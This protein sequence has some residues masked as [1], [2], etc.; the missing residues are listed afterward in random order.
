MT[1]Y[2]LSGLSPR[3]FEQLIQAIAVK[4]FG[5]KVVVFGDGPD[6]GREATF[7]G[8]VPYPSKEQG[9]NGYGIVQ[10]K[11][12]QRPLGAP[13]D[14]EWA[15]QQLRDEVTAFGAQIKLPRRKKAGPA[16]KLNDLKKPR[17][18]PEYYIFVSNAVLTPAAQ[19][20]TKDKAYAVL[21]EFKKQVGLKDFDIWDYDKICSYLDGYEDV[22]HEYGGFISTG[23]V[24]AQV[25]QWLKPQRADFKQVIYK[26]LQEELLADQYANLEQAGRATEDKIPIARVFVDLPVFA[27]QLVDPPDEQVSATSSLPTG[28]IA[29]ILEAAKERLDPI[30]VK[31]DRPSREDIVIWSIS[32]PGRYVLIG[33]PGQGKTTVGQFVCQLFRTAILKDRTARI[34]VREVQDILGLVNAQCLS[35]KIELPQARRFPIRIVLSDFAKS[36][37]A[38]DANG[39]TSLLS[40]IAAR[41]KKRTDEE[42]TPPDLRLWLCSYPWLIV[43]DGLDEVPASSNRDEVLTAIRK[44][45]IEINECNADVLIIATTRP[46]GYNQ[47]FAP[48]VYQH[49]WLAPL[50][51]VRALHYARRLI[52]VRYAADKD[53]KERVVAR[54]ERAA[55]T[56]T[57]AR[58]MRSPL[59]VTIMT[60]L[61]GTRG[62]PPQERWS[63]FNEYYKVIYQ[64]EMERE[65][66][67]SDILRTYKSDIDRIHHRVGLILQAKS[68]HSGETDARLSRDEFALVVSDR[69]TQEE[70]EGTER[71]ALQR[72]IT[73]AATDRLVFLVGLQDDQIGFEIRSLQEFMAAEALMDEGGGIIHERLREIAPIANWRNVFL[74]AAGKCFAERQELRDTIHTVCAELNDTDTD[75]VSCTTL[76]GSELAMDLLEDGVARTQPKYARLFTRLALRILRLPPLESHVRLAKLYESGLAGVYREEIGQRL[77]MADFYLQ[78]GAWA[79]LIRLIAVGVEW[80]RE[81][82][83]QH[84]VDVADDRKL[85]LLRISADVNDEDWRLSKMV[86]VLPRLAPNQ[87]TARLGTRAEQFIFKNIKGESSPK[88]FRAAQKAANNRMALSQSLSVPVKLVTS[89]NSDLLG[90]TIYKT[91]EA[92][93]QW[94]A[95]LLHMPSN[96]QEGWKPILAGVR[97][98]SDPSEVSLGR[99]L[100]TLATLNLETLKQNSHYLPWTIAACVQAASNQ[101]DL[102]SLA[103]KAERGELGDKEHWKAAEERWEERGITHED[104]KYA[105]SESALFDEYI[106]VKGFPFMAVGTWS[107]AGWEQPEDLMSLV[108]LHQD[109]K[110]SPIRE[111]LCG[112]ALFVIAA[113]F[114]RLKPKNAQRTLGI[115]HEQI[116]SI[117]RGVGELGGIIDI[118]ALNAVEWSNVLNEEWIEFLDDLGQH[119]RLRSNLSRN[120]EITKLISDAFSAHPHRIGLLRVLSYFAMAGNQS[121][122]ASTLLVPEHYNEPKF[123]GAAVIT[124]LA[125][126]KME[127]EDAEHLAQHA[128]K[129]AGDEYQVAETA[130]YMIKENRVLQEPAVDDFLVTLY[131]QLPASFW[132]VASEANQLLKVSL[133]R[134]TSRLEDINLW[135]HLGLRPALHNL[136]KESSQAMR[137]GTLRTD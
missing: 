81:Y 12:L 20:G 31:T 133:K 88:W 104:I 86:D 137:P 131:K 125:Q 112:W 39:T 29:E 134:R 68:E 33:G 120:N 11:F 19:G 93:G 123:R 91:T 96:A 46:Q 78:L 14:G 64:R 103:D 49:T 113:G 94:V 127:A 4:V 22:R 26:F 6:G 45:R 126:G 52:E 13:H 90:V 72:Q 61:V 79:C 5:P 130:L 69:L 102:N 84:W 110:P 106:A 43:L 58:L 80:A 42:V 9:W 3:S 70:H 51:V 109:L 114:R 115:S 121:T 15:I 97:F 34:P 77:V 8:M 71:D 74:F 18:P 23:D 25:I 92:E 73:E 101:R 108:Q 40:Y 1:D 27:E 41:I 66:P 107:T 67:A 21:D 116:M 136:I 128:V 117:V 28:F 36:L 62:Q 50:S 105:N 118:T 55:N 98:L 24:L 129:L 44:F 7:E 100:R 111:L 135:S 76:E 30:S 53:R 16:P 32:E 47:D 89:Q 38:S 35:E 2:N 85:D 95:D 132:E 56:D 63:L 83:E 75:V 54:L 10:A 99:E 87:I 60:T 122:V 37:A 48:E 119:Q 82:G 65:I 17:R 124:R 59:Q 57:T